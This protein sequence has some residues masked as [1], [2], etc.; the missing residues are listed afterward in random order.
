MPI[1]FQIWFFKNFL[2]WSCSSWSEIGKYSSRR[3]RKCQGK[4]FK[5]I[6]Q[7]RALIKSTH[8]N[9]LILH[10]WIVIV[11]RLVKFNISCN[12]WLINLFAKLGH[13][14][15]HG[16]SIHYRELLACQVLLSNQS[17]TQLKGVISSKSNYRYV[18]LLVCWA[19]V[20]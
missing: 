8:F 20:M 14:H 16:R 17:L 15:N 18:T 7:L 19:W 2:E 11:T 9:L 13:V 5:I 3:K 6:Y 4:R 10:F 12:A 1:C